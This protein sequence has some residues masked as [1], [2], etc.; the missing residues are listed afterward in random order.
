MKY[1]MKV[2]ALAAMTALLAVSCDSYK[3]P[4]NP[5]KL[6]EA[7]KNVS[8]TWQ[9]TKVKRNSVDISEQMDFTK[10]KLHLEESGRYSLENRLPFP[11]STDGFWEVDDPTSPFSLSFNEDDVL[12]DPVTVEISYPIVDGRRQLTITHS[13]GCNL[14]SYEYVFVKSN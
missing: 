8:G 2:Y 6:V 7:D 9:L 11:V 3:D 13:P 14:N 10:F 1:K 5:D 4:E 12:G